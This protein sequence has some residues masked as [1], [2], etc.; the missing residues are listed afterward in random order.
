MTGVDRTGTSQ[1]TERN[2]RP[3]LYVLA[4]GTQ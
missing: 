3:A 1:F 4:W 2:M